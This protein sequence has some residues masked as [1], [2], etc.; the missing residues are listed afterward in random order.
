MDLQKLDDLD[1]SV[2][3]LHALGVQLMLQDM[4]NEIGVRKFKREQAQALAAYKQPEQANVAA[5]AVFEE[6]PGTTLKEGDKNQCLMSATKLTVGFDHYTVTNISSTGADYNPTERQ[7]T[8]TMVNCP[9]CNMRRT[10][11]GRV[12][13]KLDANENPLDPLENQQGHIGGCLPE[14]D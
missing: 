11:D 13:P 8:T 4:K 10:E 14:V 12:V 2:L 3:E 9:G 1:R 5:R 6:R 7:R